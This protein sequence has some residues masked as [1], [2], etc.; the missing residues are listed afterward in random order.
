MSQLQEP[1]GVP[2]F[3]IKGG[4]TRYAKMEPQIQAYINSSDMGIN[5][6]RGQDFGWR[7]GADWVKKVRAFKQDED[8]M[9]RLTDKNGGQSPTTTQILYTIYGQQV[10]QH[11]QRLQEESAPFEEQYLRDISTQPQATPTVATPEPLPETA[12]VET[13]SPSDLKE[14]PDDVSEDVSEEDLLPPEEDESASGVGVQPEKDKAVDT[15]APV[16]ATKS[17]SQQRREAATKKAR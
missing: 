15:T 1:Q 9:A 12:P 6:S 3:S 7:L 17:K 13:D 4:E 11:R 5:A 16:P 10:R 2:F 8:K 14:Q